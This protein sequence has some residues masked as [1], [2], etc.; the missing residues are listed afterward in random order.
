MQRPWQVAALLQGFCCSSS[1][2][3]AEPP[4]VRGVAPTDLAKYT[5]RHFRCLSGSD[6]AVVNDDFCDCADGSDE[7]GTSACAGQKGIMFYCP[8]ADSFPSYVYT[9][10]VNDGI[11]D[12][13]DGSDEW[14]TANCANT[15]VQ[16]GRTLRQQRGQQLS[17]L[18][19]GIQKR[20]GLL[21]TARKDRQG[22]EKRLQELRSEL[23][24]LDKKVRHAKAALDAAQR[25]V[26]REKDA[27]VSAE[28]LEANATNISDNSQAPD[29]QAAF[30]AAVAD[31]GGSA[32]T[33]AEA[34]DAESSGVSEYSKWMDGADDLLQK[35]PKA[36]ETEGKSGD[37]AVV[38]EYTKWMDGAEKVLEEDSSNAD[39]ESEL[40][41][42]DAVADDED[43]VVE[44]E[45]PQAG[46][47]GQLR[48]YWR[49]LWRRLSWTSKSPLELQLEDAKDHH[50]AAQRSLRDATSAI[51]D[52]EKKAQ[53]A[54]NE[55]EMAYSGLEG[56]CL[57]KSVGE[58][59]YKACFFEN[60]KQDSV[61]LGRWKGWESPNLAVF[62][63]GQYCPGG[64]D[65]SL[66]VRFQC[67]PKEELLDV[68]EPSRCAYLAEVRHPAACTQALLEAVENRG[69]RHPTDEL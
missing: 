18:R 29:E 4:V 1:H 32:D 14:R 59:K 48:M 65:R 69:P 50:E 30:E 37:G 13:C 38:S 51:K 47:V 61:S 7:P 25:A 17:D 55:V 2:A 8:N 9:S 22:S 63:G 16:E 58:Y 23:P 45:I 24:G 26:D 28:G 6:P 21:E 56:R 54:E 44:D 46:F 33:K 60:A 67:G 35:A 53:A 19:S 34:A 57:E 39:G 36:S 40:D 52:L 68:S 27:K 15:C 5:T 31:A 20:Q 62:E 11:C 43:E 41:S 49:R 66:K 3:G 64:P 10:R 42:S 12:C